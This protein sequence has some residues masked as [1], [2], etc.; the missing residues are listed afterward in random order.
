MFHINKDKRF[1]TSYLFFMSGREDLNFRPPAPKAGTL[2]GLRYTPNIIIKF[3]II[4]RFYQP[5]LLQI[6]PVLLI[7][8]FQQAEELQF[9]QHPLF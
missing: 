4:Y 9:Q 8:Q 1:E 5:E 2:T 3:Q 6:F 7:C